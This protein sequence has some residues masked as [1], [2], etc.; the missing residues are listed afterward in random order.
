[1]PL[2]SVRR[3]MQVTSRVST[4]GISSGRS[5]ANLKDKDKTLALDLTTRAVVALEGGGR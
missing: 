3:G 5:Y 4:G 1:V 2:D